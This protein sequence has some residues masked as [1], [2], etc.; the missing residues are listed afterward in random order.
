[1]FKGYAIK[2]IKIEG[3]MAKNVGLDRDNNVNYECYLKSGQL[4][5]FTVPDWFYVDE[6]IGDVCPAIQLVEYM[7]WI[8][9]D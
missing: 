7:D 5:T 9:N 4:I 1:M 2:R 8:E 6:E 3:I